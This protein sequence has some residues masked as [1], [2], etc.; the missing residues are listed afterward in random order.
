MDGFHEDVWANGGQNWLRA[1]LALNEHINP[2]LVPDRTPVPTLQDMVFR[3]LSC[4]IDSWGA[5]ASTRYVEKKEDDYYKQKQ[6]KGKEENMGQG[7]AQEPQ[8]DLVKEAKNAT[9][10]EFIHNNVHVSATH[11]K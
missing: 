10:V 9:S 1:N 2:G 5:F 7:T 3:L 8:K 11:W 4:G 6:A